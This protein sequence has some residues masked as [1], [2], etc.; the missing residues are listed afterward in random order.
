[1]KNNNLNGCNV[2]VTRPAAQAQGLA[3]LIENAGGNALLFPVLKITETDDKSE[4]D[5]LIQELEHYSILIF[6]SPNAVNI[7]LGYILQQR[8]IPAN[9]KIAAVGKSSAR[10]AQL[11]LNRDIDIVPK[12]FDGHSGGYNSESLLSLPALKNVVNQ[13]IAILKGNGGRELLAT[14]LRDRGAQVSYI[15]TYQRTIPDDSELTNRIEELLTHTQDSNPICVTITS[16][17]SLTNFLTLLGEHATQ[18]LAKSQLIVINE[19][20]VSIA[21]QLGFKK[22]PLVALNASDQ[23][24]ADSVASWY[25]NKA[26]L[27]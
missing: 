18:W 12:A 7:G 10:C 25:E 21:I 22:K 19:R 5:T 8:Q 2:V 6:I 4:L 11:L 15:N 9:C 23:A 1:M 16:A 3:K 24:L 20:L 17:E 14:T 27:T 26:K 13:K